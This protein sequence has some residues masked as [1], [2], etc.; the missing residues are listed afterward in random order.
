[1]PGWTIE[2]L[3]AAEFPPET[4]DTYYDNARAKARFGRSVALEVDFPERGRAEATSVVG[5]LEGV[6]AIRWGE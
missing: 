3:D 4:G 5:G 6:R 1:M 2:P